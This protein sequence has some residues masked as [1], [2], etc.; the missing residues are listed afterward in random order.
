MYFFYFGTGDKISMEKK[1]KIKIIIQARVNSKRYKAK[2][3]SDFGP[4]KIISY[5]QKRFLQLNETG[6]YK[7]LF[8]FE[9]ILAVPNTE[10]VYFTPY[11]SNEFTLVEGSEFNVLQRFYDAASPFDCDY[12]VRATADNPFF[13]LEIIQKNLD[14]IL[15]NQREYA[16]GEADRIDYIKRTSLPLG[17]QV[18]FISKEAFI[19]AY[20]LSEK[21]YHFEHVTPF[22]YENPDIFSIYEENETEYKNIA[23]LRLTFDHDEDYAVINFIGEFFH[24]SLSLDLRDLLKLNKTQGKPLRMNNLIRQKSYKETEN[25]HLTPK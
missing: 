7:N 11:L 15:R 2:V 13:S 3:L 17:T 20:I 24:Y 22:I 4:Y 21:E 12:I 9:F 19:K 6:K 10:S 5:I 25:K 14:L 16:S 23:D 18:E 1:I 8:D